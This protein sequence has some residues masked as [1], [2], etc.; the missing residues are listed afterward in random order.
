[1]LE[2]QNNSQL[3]SKNIW[4]LEKLV[5]FGVKLYACKILDSSLSILASIRASTEK[6][7]EGFATRAL[8]AHS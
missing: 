8:V 1:M 3:S 6:N 2:F 4:D 7:G 5:W